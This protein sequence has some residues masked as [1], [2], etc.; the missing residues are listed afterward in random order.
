MY[1]KLSDFFR[2]TN[3]TCIRV[4]PKMMEALKSM[5]VNKFYHLVVNPKGFNVAYL[6]HNDTTSVGF[7]DMLRFEN[8]VSIQFRLNKGFR[9]KDYFLG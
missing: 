6:P 3:R 1:N 4:V 8:K 9:V 7:E 2:N 5:E